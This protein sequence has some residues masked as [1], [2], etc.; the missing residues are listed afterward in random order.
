MEGC[1]KQKSG[2][3]ISLFLLFSQPVESS[4]ALPGNDEAIYG[5]C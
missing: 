4:N 5:G 3:L 2:I 1:L